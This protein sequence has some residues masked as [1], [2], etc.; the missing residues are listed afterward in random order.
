LPHQWLIFFVGGALLVLGCILSCYI[1]LQRYK[2]VR[3]HKEQG[4]GEV[5]PSEADRERRESSETASEEPRKGEVP[6]EPEPRSW[7]SR[8]FFGP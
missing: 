8:F 2:A 5:S 4:D 6:S 7:L 1:L 3:L